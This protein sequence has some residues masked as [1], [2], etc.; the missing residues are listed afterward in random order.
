MKCRQ[1]ERTAFISTGLTCRYY[2]INY[3]N[4]VNYVIISMSDMCH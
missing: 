2:E 3:I 4:Y 1:S